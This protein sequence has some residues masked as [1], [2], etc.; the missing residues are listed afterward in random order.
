MLL[1]CK[2]EQKGT[3]RNNKI[4][5]YVLSTKIGIN[6]SIREFIIKSLI[7]KVDLM[8]I[9]INRDT[10]PENSKSN[11]IELEIE[12]IKNNIDQLK[13]DYT[14]SN[15]RIFVTVG[16]DFEIDDKN[17]GLVTIFENNNFVNNSFLALSILDDLRSNG[18]IYNKLS[19]MVLYC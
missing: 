16:N 3:I 19:D 8:V 9:Y 18:D 5:L 2:R 17:L 14:L 12:E 11:N 10:L 13:S 1:K 4:G 7:E 15:D 6:V